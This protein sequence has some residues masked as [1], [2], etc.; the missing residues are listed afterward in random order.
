MKTNIRHSYHAKDGSSLADS[1]DEILRDEFVLQGVGVEQFEQNLEHPL[2]LRPLRK[3]VRQHDH[4]QA[5]R[6]KVVP[7]MV[8]GRH[9]V[10]PAVC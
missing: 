5:T 8:I 9:K 2:K 3:Q 1:D 6:H 7:L 10:V 4:L